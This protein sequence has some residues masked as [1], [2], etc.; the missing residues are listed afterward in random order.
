MSQANDEPE[1]A[2]SVER[3]IQELQ[4][5]HAKDIE[6]LHAY[7]GYVRSQEQEHM[8]RSFQL[9]DANESVLEVRSLVLSSAP[10]T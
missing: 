4:A 7:Y 2:S 10:Q 8:R 1:T 5:R 6:S 3:R 9:S